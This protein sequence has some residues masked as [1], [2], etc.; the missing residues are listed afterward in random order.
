MDDSPSRFVFF[1]SFFLTFVSPTTARRSGGRGR[2]YVRHRCPTP[3][4]GA[5]FCKV[6][7]SL[8][9]RA[10]RSLVKLAFGRAD[11]AE[12]AKRSLT[13]YDYPRSDRS[14]DRVLTPIRRRSRVTS[15]RKK[16][17]R[18]ATSPSPLP[19]ARVTTPRAR[20]GLPKF[21]SSVIVR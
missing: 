11:N 1:F 2:A 12:A 14:I 19:L 21:P 4:R 15:S 5:L 18:G 6:T 16:D 3:L 8:R 13:R 7:S 20:S 10:A 17:G 9:D